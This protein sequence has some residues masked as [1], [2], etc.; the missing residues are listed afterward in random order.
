VTI[1]EIKAAAL[2]FRAESRQELYDTIK[3]LKDNNVSFP[4]CAAFLQYNLQISLADARRQ[5]LETDIWTAKEKDEINGYHL[6]M[7]S[8]FDEEED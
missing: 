4:G 1:N 5:L 7:I 2:T 6:L 8:E 3:E